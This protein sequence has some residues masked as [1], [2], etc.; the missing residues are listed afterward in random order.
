MDFTKE[1]LIRDLEILPQ[2]DASVSNR[3]FLQ[4][5]SLIELYQAFGELCPLD[6][7]EFEE[8]IIRRCKS[9]LKKL[10]KGEV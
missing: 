5:N 4:Y 9:W 10:Y 6:Q 1:G 2:E 3:S 7:Y 8:D